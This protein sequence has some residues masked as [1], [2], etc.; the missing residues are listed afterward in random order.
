[1]LHL[2]TIAPNTLTLLK[3]IQSLSEFSNTRLVGGTSLALQLG[4]RIS[5]DLDLFGDWTEDADLYAA[6]KQIGMA[7]KSS[8]TPNGK[9][10]FF[11][12]NDVKVDCVDYSDYPWLDPPV[13]EAGVR[14]ASVRD[15]GAMKINAITNRG[16][17]KDFVDLA[18]L[19]QHYAI[20]EI[21]D[22]Y[23]RKYPDASVAL[24]L[25]SMAY[26]VDAETMPL[27]RLLQPFDWEEAKDS[28]RASVR[29]MVGHA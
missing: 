13:E 22:W 29:E 10:Q 9:L 5:I 8:G 23:K 27:P 14:L 4:H 17:R 1:M 19:L 12:V 2:E 21:F 24:A 16:T 6:L 20:S 11:Y 3:R 26:F 25:R 15:I 28:I 7:R 18:F